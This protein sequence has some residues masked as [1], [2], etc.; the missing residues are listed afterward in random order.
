MAYNGRTLYD[1]SDNT[2]WQI[3]IGT[4]NASGTSSLNPP[5]AEAI[6]NNCQDIITDNSN[7][8]ANQ[9]T[10]TTPTSTYF[11]LHYQIKI[12]T[13]SLSQVY[14]TSAISA[15]VPVAGTK[16]YDSPYNMWCM[17]YGPISMTYGADTV[18][19]DKDINLAAAMAFSK[20]NTSNK[21][22]DFQILPFCPLPEEYINADGSITVNTPSITDSNT[23]RDGSN[24]VVGFIFA[25]PYCTFTKQIL[26]NSPITVDDPK[27]DSIEN[28]YRLYSPNYASSF[29]FSLA[30]N[31]GLRGFNIRCTYMP[32]SPYIRIAPIWG[33][34]Y[35][36]SGF[37]KD[38]RGLVCTGDYSLPR[39]T[40]AWV[41]YQEQN[42][43]FES[44]FNREIENM[45]V[46]RKYQL[47]E[48]I[49]NAGAGVVAGAAAGAAAGS[50]IPGIGTAV[51]AVVGGVTAAGTGIA[52]LY[53]GQ[54]RFEE[55]K[56]YATAMHAMQLENVRAMPRTLSKTTAFNVDNRYF[57]VFVEYGCTLL[58]HVAVMQFLQNRS[59]NVGVIDKPQNYV[60]TT[61]GD[62]WG[63]PDRGFICGSIIK[64]DTV[65]DTH[66]VDELN[67]EFQMGVYTR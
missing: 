33:G 24:N 19:A 5:A 39:I 57:P 37:D 66:F 58:E 63:Y 47:I 30:K 21:I 38:P 6:V 43:N 18:T 28:I 36:D 50:F 65:F 59:M 62:S 41:N 45:D 61:W 32:I 10:Y 31:G 29:E 67:K 64:I 56:S 12:I 15:K 53:I 4:V 25:C 26:L 40:D 9:E 60:G 52:D 34:I 23:M 22:Y 8:P 55:N 44:I 2:Y 14:P 46:M 54:K 17:P 42:K 35:G 27:T 11:T 49:A 48:Q 20:E 7:I 51:G 13:I 1:E 3:S 16:P